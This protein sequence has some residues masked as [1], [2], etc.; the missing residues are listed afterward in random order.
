M[1][2]IVTCTYLIL[3]M[4]STEGIERRIPHN[5][6][7]TLSRGQHAF[8]FRF[9]KSSLVNLSNALDIDPGILSKEKKYQELVD[10]GCQQYLYVE[11]V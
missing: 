3:F 1:A 5:G 4:A 2:K 10:N 6:G 9:A 11:S 8:N 7:E